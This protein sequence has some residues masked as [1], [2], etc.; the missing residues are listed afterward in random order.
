MAAKRRPRSTTVLARLRRWSS[1][2]RWALW[3]L[4]AIVSIGLIAWVLSLLDLT[5]FSQVLIRPQWDWLLAMIVAAWL[6]LLLGGYKYWLLI[7]THNRVPLLPF[8]GYFIMASS[9]GTYT[10]A[11]LGEFSLVGFLRREH[12]P[13]H[14]GLAI[15]LVDRVI[16]LLVYVAVFLPLTVALLIPEMQ[17]LWLVP[18]LVLLGGTG[19]LI[20]FNRMTPLRMW[21]YNHLQRL[22]M[23]FLIDFLATISRLIRRH[24]WYLG[25]NITV[26]LLRCV[27]SAIVVMFA[28]WAAGEWPPFKPVLYVTNSLS[29]LALLP[30]S[31]AGIGV[32]EGGGVTLLG[33][34]G[35]D[36]ERIF[37]ALLYQRIYL[38]VSSPIY[39]LLIPLVMGRLRRSGAI[40][41]PKEPQ[42]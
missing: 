22:Q 41:A 33:Q 19:F 5:N 1:H 28:L 30:V 37:A 17:F 21:V 34:L 4:Q 3:T 15:I 11:S 16:T 39:L 26:T 8:L 7:R 29:L 40:A 31:V 6:Y 14:E 25:A 12:V 42:P 20:L 32:Y 18:C 38:L 24:P 2:H 23:Q 27:A 13:V 36:P 35:L 9:I 10:P